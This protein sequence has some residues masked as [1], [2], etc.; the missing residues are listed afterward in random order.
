MRRVDNAAS[1]LDL[2]P[3]L[4]RKPAALLPAQRLCVAIGRAVARQPKVFLF[5]DPLSRLSPPER[6]QMRPVLL[7]LHHHLQA[8]MIH[9]TRDPREALALGGRIVVLG[10]GK[11]ARIEQ[12]G[13]PSEIYNRP[14]NL[15][16]AGFAGEPPMNFLKGMLR[17]DGEQ[18]LF[19]E[20]PGGTL[21]IRLGSRSA[22]DAWIGKDVVL[23][24]RPE[25]CEIPPAGKP[26][27]ENTFQVLAD[28]VET[29]GADTHFHADTGAHKLL[30]RSRS[31][32]G[33]EGAGHR[34]RIQIHGAGVH[35]FD[36]S[37]GKAIR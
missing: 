10:E 2:A 30:I 21:E 13:T 37:S 9:G 26:P 25:D 14:A 7:K 16:V 3:L 18:I 29:F 22:A 5:D 1:I 11:P 17:K 20:P 15:F 35:L 4:D 27:Q 19:K 36:P 23:G 12:A 24:L 6:E 34:I 33:T 31:V 8:T 28:L 32:I